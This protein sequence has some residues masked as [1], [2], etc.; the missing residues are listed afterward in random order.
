MRCTRKMGCGYVR[1]E[2]RYDGWDVLSWKNSKPG[3]ALIFHFFCTYAEATGENH[4]IWQIDTLQVQRDKF[5]QKYLEPNGRK[6][7]YIK[8]C[9]TQQK[10]K[11]LKSRAWII[12]S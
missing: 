7:L 5:Q 12:F 2:I 8:T 4:I 3:S 11:I 10:I 6:T 1:Y 9:D